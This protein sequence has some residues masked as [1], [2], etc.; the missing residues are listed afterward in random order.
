M[1]KCTPTG[2]RD[3]PGWL[4]QELAE[5]KKTM[6]MQFSQYWRSLVEFEHIWR[7][8]L[9]AV[10]QACKPLRNSHAVKEIFIVCYD[11]IIAIQ[12]L[13][14]FAGRP[15]CYVQYIYVC[16]CVCVCSIMG[17]LGVICD[18][19]SPVTDTPVEVEHM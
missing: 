19:T 3:L 5:L 18:F 10:Q 11:H 7:K 2:S 14:V 6:L 8:C 15:P 16:V 13:T 4:M 17:G 1:K 12:T 9:E